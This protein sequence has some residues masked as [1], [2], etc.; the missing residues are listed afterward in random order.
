MTELWLE[1]QS[2]DDNKYYVD[3]IHIATLLF[4]LSA[5]KY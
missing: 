1:W 4:L 3:T 2:S 5:S